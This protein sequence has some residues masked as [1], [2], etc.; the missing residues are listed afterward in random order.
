MSMCS[1][2][3]IQT[4]RLCKTLLMSFGFQSTIKENDYIVKDLKNIIEKVATHL[5]I[6]K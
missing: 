1:Q 2:L 3:A 4:E 6:E 5:I